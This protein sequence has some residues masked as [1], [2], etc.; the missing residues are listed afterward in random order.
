MNTYTYSHIYNVCKTENIHCS[1]RWGISSGPL[2]FRYPRNP[3]D[4]DRMRLDSSY[5]SNLNFCVCL[6]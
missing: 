4:E 2:R 6:L 3:D 1:G 5:F